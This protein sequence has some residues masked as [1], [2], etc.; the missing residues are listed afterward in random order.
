MSFFRRRRR[1]DEE[2]QRPILIAQFSDTH[3]VSTVGIM[4]PGGIALDDG[5]WYRPSK[6]QLGL[7]D[8]YLR[9]WDRIASLKRELNAHCLAMFTGD[10]TDDNKHSKYQLATVNEAV[11]I[12]A[13]VAVLQPALDVADKLFYTRGTEAH[14]GGSGY[15][16]E[17]M[18]MAVGAVQTDEMKEREV[19]SRWF[20]EL[21]DLYGLRALFSHHPFSS[22]W[23]PWTEGSGANRTAMAIE[24]DYLRNG[25]P[26]P[27][28]AGFGHVHHFE[29]SGTT[30]L[31]RAFFCPSFTLAGAYVHRRGRGWMFNPVGAM[32]YIIYPNGSWTFDKVTFLPRRSEPWSMGL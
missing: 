30:H 18:A 9:Y 22:S 19:W 16:E 15:L 7:W 10:G 21:E 12:K 13:G 6:S 17:L 32:Y 5:G 27:D 26:V 3:P 1:Q 31:C 14:V 25:K 8:G 20:W 11:M 24:I 23:V 28:F 29:D 2:E 4:A